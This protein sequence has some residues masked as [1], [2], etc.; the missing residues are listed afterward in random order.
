M[1]MMPDFTFEVKPVVA[2]KEHSKSNDLAN[3][4][5]THGI[6]VTAAFGKISVTK[7]AYSA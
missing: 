7:K 3:H 6:E 2:R 5:L 4:Y 1:T